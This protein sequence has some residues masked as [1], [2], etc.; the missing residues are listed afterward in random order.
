MLTR[1][2]SLAVA[3]ASLLVAAC[4]SPTTSV[5]TDATA[6]AAA[7]ASAPMAA[8]TTP[9]RKP[10]E[11][12]DL[13]AYFFV[14]F[15]DEHHSPCFALSRDGYTF[16]ALNDGTPVMDG[17]RL[18]EQKGIRD[19][20]IARGG[21]GAFYLTMTD[22]HVYGQR[23][24]HRDTQWERPA[25]LYDWGNNRAI[26]MMR[27]TD[28]INWSYAH[29]RMDKAFEETR[30]VG[31]FWAPQ[32]IYDPARDRMMV[33]FTMRLGHGKTKLYYSYADAAFTKLE[34]VPVEYFQY[35][36]GHQILD[37]DITRVGDKYHLFYC[38]QG[39]GGGIKQAVSDHLTHGYVYDP[40]TYDPERVGREAPSVWK[41]L[42]TD[43]Y[44]LMYDV[45]GVN[46]HNYGFAE[47]TDFKHF[48]NLGR[49]NEG[50]MRATNF[51]SPKHGSIVH[52]TDAE[53]R[54]LA[55]YWKFDY[56]SLPASKN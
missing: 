36:P 2:A 47:T 31:C 20:H 17:T 44:V 12:K 34:T 22:L 33:Y 39:P 51:S 53:A 9:A 43:R 16:T 21:D 40:A 10:I 11:E 41:R 32:S 23:A 18:A 37:G 52:L 14:Y 3:A 8:P 26:V 30:D 56:D 24:G 55:A 38:A 46:P 50:V 29:F 27:S 35:P 48:E 54:A 1:L 5:S 13:G 7:L 6:S 19:P 4:S 28:L 45:F 25:E 42:G 15:K 49:L